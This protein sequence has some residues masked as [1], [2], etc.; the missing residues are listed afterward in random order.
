M[1]RLCSV[2]LFLLQSPTAVQAFSASVKAPLVTYEVCL[3]PTCADDGARASFNK[4]QAFAPPGMT[5]VAGGCTNNMH[6]GHGPVVTSSSLDN[7]N[8]KTFHRRIKDAG[9]IVKLLA[10]ASSSDEDSAA[11]EIIPEPLINGYNTYLQA[12]E[13]FRLGQYETADILYETAVDTGLTKAME[14][15]EARELVI[16]TPED[17]VP[18]GLLWA[19]QGHRHWAIARI[20]LNDIPGAVQVA[21]T[22]CQLSRNKCSRSLDVLA[23][24]FQHQ[25]DKVEELATLSKLF[26][27]TVDT[28]PP[29]LQVENR[30]REQTYRKATL[31]REIAGVQMEGIFHPDGWVSWTDH[32]HHGQDPLH[33]K[34]I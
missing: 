28:P 25:G 31:E 13:A 27:L 6:C 11:A 14:L 33:R 26:E 34:K 7:N 1:T 23:E 19:A 5:V 20:A 10:S 24:C 4:L 22:A 9:Q 2:L 16:A 18:T 30:R 32:N 17:Q 8:K 21:Q 3:S 12:E 29:N 15:Q